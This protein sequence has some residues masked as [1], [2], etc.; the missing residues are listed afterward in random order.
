MH[1]LLFYL[2]NLLNQCYKVVL[3]VWIGVLVVLELLLVLLV[4]VDRSRSDSARLLSCVSNA[5]GIWLVV[6]VCVVFV[7]CS[8]RGDVC[9]ILLLPLSLV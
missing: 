8:S 9:S 3:L 7:V 2:L 4:S 5:S 6:L 1:T